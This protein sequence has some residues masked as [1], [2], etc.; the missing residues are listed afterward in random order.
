MAD[1]ERLAKQHAKLADERN[2]L[3]REGAAELEKCSRANATPEGF[4]NFGPDSLKNRLKAD[5][6][7]LNCIEAA[8]ANLDGITFE[9][10]WPY[11]DIDDEDSMACIHCQNTRELRKLRV[12]AGIQLGKIRTGITLAGR[13]LL[14][15][16]A[17]KE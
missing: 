9:E 4:N 3:K 7:N 10:A 14:K 11:I 16:E 12:A 6:E 5:Y 1:L 13:H 8:Y 2:R 17:E 15:L